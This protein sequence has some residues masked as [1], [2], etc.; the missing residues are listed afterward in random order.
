MKQGFRVM[1]SDLHTMEPDDLWER[2]LEPPFK[3]FAPSFAR[4]A[5]APSQQPTIRV[6]HLTIGDITLR[7][8]SVAAGAS[9]QGGVSGNSKRKILWDNCARLY[10]LA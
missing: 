3:R 2:Y 9:L 8:K 5:G 10:G 6:G 1:D 7:P 4:E